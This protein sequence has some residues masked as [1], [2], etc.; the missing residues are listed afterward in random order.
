MRCNL[1]QELLGIDSS[2]FLV[3]KVVN[4]Q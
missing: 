1:A 4:A 2:L 3:L